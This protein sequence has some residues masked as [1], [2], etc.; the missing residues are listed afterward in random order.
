MTT[1]SFNAL[2]VNFD[3]FPGILRVGSFESLAIN[4]YDE[5]LFNPPGSH[6]RVL[7]TPQKFSIFCNHLDVSI[8]TIGTY[9]MK[10]PSKK[11][12][13]QST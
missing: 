5:S 3:Q 6:L 8:Q 1:A 9:L 11:I 13:F 12:L 10:N 2:N 4:M 7:T